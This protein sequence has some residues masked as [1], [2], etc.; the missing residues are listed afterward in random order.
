MRVH[1]RL[2]GGSV[3]VPPASARAITE[4]RI[5]LTIRRDKER[6]ASNEELR[7]GDGAAMSEGQQL[8][9]RALSDSEVLLFDLN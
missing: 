5:V 1:R 3:G 8:Q 2:P 7:A 4:E 9:L 6:G